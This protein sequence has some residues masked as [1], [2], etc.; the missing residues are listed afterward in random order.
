MA[1]FFSVFTL[2]ERN[3][4]R[5]ERERALRYLLGKQKQGRWQTTWYRSDLYA[6]SRVCDF[7]LQFIESCTECRKALESARAYVIRRQRAD[8]SWGKDAPSFLDTAFALQIL[9]NS[10]GG[11]NLLRARQFLLAGQLIEG[12]WPAEP[13]FFLDI[14]QRS[15]PEQHFIGNKLYSTAIVLLALRD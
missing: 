13:F 14:S 15:R 3:L 5:E 4:F 1:Y 8:G 11:Q 10:G 9:K 7:I 12:A 2:K 6:T